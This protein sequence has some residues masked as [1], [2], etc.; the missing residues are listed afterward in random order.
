MPRLVYSNEKFGCGATIEL[1]SQDVCIISVAQAE[2]FG[3]IVSEGIFR[4]RLWPCVWP[5][6]VQREKCTRCCKCCRFA[7][8]AISGED[9]GFEINAELDVSRLLDDVTFN[10][11]QSH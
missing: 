10:D 7:R 8:H 1:D 2:G 9:S 6:I 5:H 4:W 11:L 3:S